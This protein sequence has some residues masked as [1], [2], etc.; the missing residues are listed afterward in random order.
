M[1]VFRVL[2]SHILASKKSIKRRWNPGEFF[3]CKTS[4]PGYPTYQMILNSIGS[5]DYLLYNLNKKTIPFVA[6]SFPRALIPGLILDT[7]GITIRKRMQ[8]VYVTFSSSSATDLGSRA[9]FIILVCVFCLERNQ[10]T[11]SETLKNI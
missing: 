1:S 7:P 4:A 9:R 6:T 5:S 3:Y 10:Y 11:S 2:K 8:T